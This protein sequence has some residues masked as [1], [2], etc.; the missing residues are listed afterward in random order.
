M[1]FKADTM[2]TRAPR[3]A[4]AQA[5]RRA[6]RRLPADELSHSRA[7]S[8]GRGIGKS[9]VLGGPLTRELPAVAEIEALRCFAKGVAVRRDHL[10]SDCAHPWIE[11]VDR[12][13]HPAAGESV[14]GPACGVGPPVTTGALLRQTPRVSEA[15][16]AFPSEAE[17]AESKRM[18][19]SAAGGRRPRPLPESSDAEDSDDRRHPRRR[20]G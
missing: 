12:G 10:I 3:R 7:A 9:P 2:V 1:K 20:R 18:R 5:R 4:I 16:M 8:G 6:P 14:Q 17:R 19:A 13:G 11:I 15:P